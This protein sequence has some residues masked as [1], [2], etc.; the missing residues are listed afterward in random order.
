MHLRQAALAL[1]DAAIA[2]ELRFLKHSETDLLQIRRMDSRLQFFQMVACYALTINL[3]AFVAF[4]I[5]KV[6]AGARGRRISEDRL[7]SFAFMG[8]W[9]GAYAGR[10]LFRHKT[11]KQPFSTLLHSIA[12]IE[13]VAVGGL[14]LWLFLR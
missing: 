5:D 2:R 9:P 14:G 13:T 1:M 4:G 10:H 11:R 6:Q 3:V 12:V 7:L 8:G